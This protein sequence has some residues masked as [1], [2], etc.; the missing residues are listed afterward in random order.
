M[1]SFQDIYKS[2]G[3]LNVLNGVSLHLRAG[4]SYALVGPNGSGKTTLIKSLLG[5]VIP[6]KGDITFKGEKINRS[7]KYRNQI[8][9]MPQIGRYPENMRI[10][11]LFDMMRNIRKDCD[12]LDEELIYEFDL[13]KMLDK[14]MHTLSGGTRQKVSAALAFLFNPPVLILDEPTA[15]LDPVA[16]EF[17][18]DKIKKELKKGKLLLITSH[19]LSDLDELSN[20]LIYINEGKIDYFN[21]IEKLK[22]ETGEEQLSKALARL[23]SMVNTK[24]LKEFTS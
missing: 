14:P 22:E 19:I 20:E 5:M 23:I 1:I 2:F 17:L 12:E 18:K 9:Y 16:V 15:G 21:A 10:G 6:D 11:Q 13:N 3:K 8:G 4:Q 7:W 24:S